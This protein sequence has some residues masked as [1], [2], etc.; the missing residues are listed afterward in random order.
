MSN[1]KFD[2]VINQNQ[3]ITLAAG[4]QYPNA[5]KYNP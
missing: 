3:L 4:N 2:I 5:A 1:I